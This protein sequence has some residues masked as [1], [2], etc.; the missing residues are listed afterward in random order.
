M[1]KKII[2]RNIGIL[3]C[4]IFVMIL[5]EN[6]KLYYI[7]TKFYIFATVKKIIAFKNYYRDFMS[8][9]SS[10]ER[11]K[12]QRALLLFETE[13]R[14]P[15]HYIHYI[16]DGLYEFRVTCGKKEFRLFFIYDGEIIVV[17][18]NCFT[19]KSKKTPKREIEK[20]IKLKEEYYHAK[21]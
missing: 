11:D 19:K 10:F 21:E 5:I 14:I 17:I 15:R 7:T 8:K 1:I 12:I 4:L 18:F 13:D 2:K 3:V 20:S 9:L 16:R 6:K